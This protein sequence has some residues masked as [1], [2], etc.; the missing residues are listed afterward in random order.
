MRPTEVQPAAVCAICRTWIAR[1]GDRVDA[2]LAS[3]TAG[4]SARPPSPAAAPTGGALSATTRVVAARVARARAA[5][6]AAGDRVS[7]AAEPARRVGT[8][9]SWSAARG[10]AGA[11]GRTARPGSFWEGAHARRVAL[12][13]VDPAALLSAVKPAARCSGPV[14]VVDARVEAVRTAQ[15]RCDE[16]AHQLESAAP[17]RRRAGSDFEDAAPEHRLPARTDA[18]TAVPSRPGPDGVSVEARGLPESLRLAERASRLSVDP[19]PRPRA[20]ILEHESRGTSDQSRDRDLTA[21]HGH[22]DRLIAPLNEDLLDAV[23]AP[24]ELTDG[25]DRTIASYRDDGFDEHAFAAGDRRD[26]RVLAGRPDVGS[27]ANEV[28]A[29]LPPDVRHRFLDGDGAFAVLTA[30]RGCPVRRQGDSE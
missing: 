15:A 8:S 12:E 17:R 26:A 25:R 6:V 3:G 24:A 16:G 20:A 10:A 27:P 1:S 23:E 28:D 2:I 30:R 19:Y 5:D 13:R 18:A 4:R 21:V 11:F 14:A 29:R 22:R 9:G 7:G